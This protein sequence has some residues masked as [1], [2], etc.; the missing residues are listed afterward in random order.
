[1]RR[2]QENVVSVEE[3]SDF[4]A[5]FAISL[6]G[7]GTQTSRVLRNV[8][9][10]AEGFG[11]K[12]ETIILPRT[13]I[14][15][16]SSLSDMSVYRTVVRKVAPM[17]L[18]FTLLARLRIL[19]WQVRRTKMSF[20]ECKRRYQEILS[21]PALSGWP[22]VFIVSL[23]NAAFCQL[24]GGLYSIPLVFIGTFFGFSAKTFLLSRKINTLLS[25]LI[26]AF[27]SSFI[28]GVMVKIFGF[29]TDIALSTSV[30]FLI[31]GVPL[32]N[33]VI[34][35]IEGHVLAGISRMVNAVSII[36]AIAL[37]LGATIL[38]LN[39]NYHLEFSRSAVSG[40]MYSALALDAVFAAVAG[41][42]FGAVFNPPK[43]ALAAAGVLA[44]VGHSFR[45]MLM[46]ACSMDITLATLLAAFLIG[47]GAFV[48]GRVSKS[49]AETCAFPA[50][51]PMVPGL[52]AYRAF[53]SVL[54]FLH[55]RDMDAAARILPD[56]FSYGFT[57]VFV[58]F[59]IV[60]GASFAVFLDT[61]SVRM[62]VKG[63]S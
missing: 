11:Y 46:N 23:G 14:M 61:L 24:F 27:V 1:M 8:D 39:I 9:R 41:I 42:G 40:A 52:M 5:D 50:L 63:N 29:K 30:L 26:S 19:T 20:G 43:A 18:N 17:P 15:T 3:V 60:I 45:F 44:A 58:I 48:F 62:S 6:L 4:L 55:A 36:I 16:L 38:L 47:I 37:G 32:I 2:K 54:K 21:L 28:T 7:S 13:I 25:I 57:A 22:L 53:L 33:S 59:A 10:L 56:L 34:D 31:P 51:L 35:L 49:P 12:A